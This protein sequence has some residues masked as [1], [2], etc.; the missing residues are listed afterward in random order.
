M[1]SPLKHLDKG[2][3][4]IDAAGQSLGRVVSRAAGVLQGKHRPDYAPNKDLG[5][6]V[7]IMNISKAVFTGK[8]FDQK[9]YFRFSG[10]PGGLK[11][12]S[13]KVLWAKKPDEVIRKM[14]FRM[15]PANRLRPNRMKR[16][17]ITE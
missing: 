7:H 15:L 3:H 1:T 8:K 2:V 17:R 11:E 4:S 5:R 12:E 10:Y 9:K 16:L 6:P 13:L 14:V